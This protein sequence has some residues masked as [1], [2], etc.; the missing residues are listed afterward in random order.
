MKLRTCSRL[1][2]VLMAVFFM[3]ASP[4]LAAAPSLDKLFNHFLMAMDH[5][6]ITGLDIT[7]YGNYGWVTTDQV[8]NIEAAKAAVVEFFQFSDADMGTLKGQSQGTYDTYAPEINK[9]YPG[10]TY[11]SENFLKEVQTLL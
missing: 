6:G 10:D 8:K 1:W 4:A 9:L 11:T 2:L 7:V 5:K 3:F